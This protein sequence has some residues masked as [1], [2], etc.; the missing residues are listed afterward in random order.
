MSLTKMLLAAG[1][2]ALP[3][4]TGV[5][6]EAPL[7]VDID[8]KATAPEGLQFPMAPRFDV[9]H[10][11]KLDTYSIHRQAASGATIPL[12]SATATTAGTNYTYTM[13]G[14]NPF[15]TLSN[16]STTIST[17]IIPVKINLKTSRRSTT[18]F[19]PTATDAHGCLPA[20]K[21]AISLTQASPIFQNVTIS[22]AGTSQYTDLFQRANFFTQTVNG[23][24][25]GY[26]VL[27]SP[28]VGSTVTM[29]ISGN[30]GDLAQ[31]NCG[32]GG[33]DLGL[34]DINAFDSTIQNTVFPQLASQLNANTFPLF[35]L[36]N[37]VMFDG[38]TSNCCILG[39]HNAFTFNG[40]FQTYGVAEFDSSN[41][42]SGTGNV[43]AMSHEVGEWMDDPNGVN[44]T[45]SWG[46]I[47][48]V[49]GCQT[50]LEVGD[51]LSGTV[52]TFA[53]NGF[54][55]LLQDL[56]F[57][58]WFYRASPSGSL[59]GWYSLQGTFRSPSAAC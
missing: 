10:S 43:S 24:N 38:S 2:L 33:A 17:V 44:P 14:Q 57:H 52:E 59:N 32:N 9:R 56:A 40:L 16:P 48:Q 45:P 31:A 27:L 34:I 4:A 12:W 22:G 28:T 30:S 36:Y 3:L 11:T 42:F 49:S 26:H 35:V 5:A 21:T 46:N 13:V 41:L 18:T 50:N 47:G 37:V 8:M 58:N 6:A 53:L 7:S 39:Y 20:G 55:Y 25:P 19:D 23:A 29:N 51:P 15:V 54:N 1:L